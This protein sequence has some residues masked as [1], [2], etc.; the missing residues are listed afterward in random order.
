MED[1]V[2]ALRDEVRA[3]KDAL[4]QAEQGRPL[5]AEQSAALD[6]VV[7]MMTRVEALSWWVGRSKWLIAAIV[8]AYI[9]RDR[10]AE[11]LR[12]WSGK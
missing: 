6:W 12:I 5:T 11:T 8:V 10:L 4:R 7:Q 2:V 1:Q 3:L 9:Q